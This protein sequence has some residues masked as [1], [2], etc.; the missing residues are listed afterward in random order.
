MELELIIFNA[1]V[2]PAQGCRRTVM[3]LARHAAT[4]VKEWWY[5]STKYTV[6]KQR[7]VQS[8]K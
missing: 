6:I 8:C 1:H 4:R 3:T 7:T 5:T 2:H